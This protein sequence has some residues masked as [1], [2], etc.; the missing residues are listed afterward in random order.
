MIKGGRDCVFVVS[1]SIERS[2]ETSRRSGELHIVSIQCLL[3][4]K[5][6]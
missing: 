5:Y 3:T 1:G 6:H 2:Q 4:Y